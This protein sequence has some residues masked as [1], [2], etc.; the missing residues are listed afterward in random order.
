[1]VGAWAGNKVYLSET[2]PDEKFEDITVKC[3][4]G[5]DDY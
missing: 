4:F 3:D 1:M 2:K 5:N